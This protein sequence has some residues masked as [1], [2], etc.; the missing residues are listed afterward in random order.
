[1]SRLVP[2][3]V[4]ILSGLP[5]TRG[6]VAAWDLVGAV[7]IGPFEGSRWRGGCVGELWDLDGAIRLACGFCRSSEEHRSLDK[8][9]QYDRTGL[10]GSQGEAFLKAFVNK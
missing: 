8:F 3:N 2:R 1:M 4:R 9:R 10:L 7:V 5:R 6:W